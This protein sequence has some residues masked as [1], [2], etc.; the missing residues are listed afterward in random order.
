[1]DQSRFI[2]HAGTHLRFRTQMGK[3]LRL[4]RFLQAG[5]PSRNR[6]LTFCRWMLLGLLLCL[7]FWFS[8]K[9]ASATFFFFVFFFSTQSTQ[10]CWGNAGISVAAA[11]GR[12]GG[13]LAVR[14]GRHGP[15]QGGRN[16]RTGPRRPCR[17][18][19]VHVKPGASTALGLFFFR[20]RFSTQEMLA[21]L[22]DEK[23]TRIAKRLQIGKLRRRCRHPGGPASL[24]PS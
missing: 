18:C 19:R 5:T 14:R 12:M 11:G 2:K 23:L 24:R 20:R 17:R 7:F 10:E 6:T 15:W 22:R 8:F 16:D 1:M 9:W 4:P 3:A 13:H 21:L